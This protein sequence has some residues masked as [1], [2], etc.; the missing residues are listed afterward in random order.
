M[1]N[2]FTLITPDM[3]SI[4]QPPQYEPDWETTKSPAPACAPA[5][6]QRSVHTLW[7]RVEEWSGE[8]CCDPGEACSKVPH[9][10]V[11]C[12]VEVRAVTPGCGGGGGHQS[13]LGDTSERM[14]GR[15]KVGAEE[16]EEQESR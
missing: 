3:V 11:E 4:H 2:R 6:H 1:F 13:Q 14:G 16:E 15:W 10:W 5:Y 12:G 9:I 8:E 7:L